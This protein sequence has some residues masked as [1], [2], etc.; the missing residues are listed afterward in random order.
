MSYTL[1]KASWSRILLWGGVVMTRARTEPT[2]MTAKLPK[3]PASA[4][5]TSETR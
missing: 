2:G 3:H 5:K 1:C 4:Q